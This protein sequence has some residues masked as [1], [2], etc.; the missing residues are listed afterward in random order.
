MSTK[1]KTE[2]KPKTV[3]TARMQGLANFLKIGRTAD[4]IMKTYKLKSVVASK[5]L[6]AQAV[7]AGFKISKSKSTK[8]ADHVGRRPNVYA[9]AG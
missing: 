1:K 3:D 6:V 4:Q 5:R 9:F 7:K 8:A 2:K